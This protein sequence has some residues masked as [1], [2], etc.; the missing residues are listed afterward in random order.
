MKLFKQVKDLAAVSLKNPVKIFINQSTDTALSLRQEFVRIRA[1][2]EGE[3][4]AI[5]A[6]IY[7]IISINH[8]G[9]T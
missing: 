3:R 9:I 4:E 6:G 2:R 1:N 5:I 8:Y 7:L